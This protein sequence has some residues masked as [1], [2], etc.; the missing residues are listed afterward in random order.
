MPVCNLQITTS[1]LL[2]MR[3]IFDQF[4]GLYGLPV[5]KSE[6]I[7]APVGL[8]KIND[9]FILLTKMFLEND[10]PGKVNDLH[11][12]VGNRCILRENGKN[13]VGRIR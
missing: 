2:R 6:G 13:P 4:N 9:I 5:L 10:S 1:E 12:H 7:N 11:V 8:R 3:L